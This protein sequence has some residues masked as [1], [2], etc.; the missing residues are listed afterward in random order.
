MEAKLVVDELSS[1]HDHL[2]GGLPIIVSGGGGTTGH[3][4]PRMTD[5][6]TPLPQFQLLPHA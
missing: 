1:S 4:C 3:G 5:E 2:M 6:L